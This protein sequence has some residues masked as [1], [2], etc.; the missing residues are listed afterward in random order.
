MVVPAVL[1]FLN[2][3]K[4]P[5]LFNMKEQNIITMKQL[6]IVHNPSLNYKELSKTWS[7]EADF[8]EVT[9]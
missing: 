7:L 4:T 3:S 9:R 1:N 8:N 2:L 6:V 5:Q